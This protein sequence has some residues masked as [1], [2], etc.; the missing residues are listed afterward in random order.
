M[1]IRPSEGGAF[2]HVVSLARGLAEHG[3]EVALCGPH[4]A[5]GGLGVELLELDIQRPLSLRADVGSIRGLRR[6]L[7]DYGP[8]LIHAHG[9]KGG[10]MARVARRA[11]VGAPLVFTPHGYAFAGHFSRRSERQAYRAIERA[12]SPLASRVICVCQAEAR[13]AASV[14]S[15]KRI[16]VVY[17]GID[18]PPGVASDP[19]IAALPGPVISAVTGLRP[20]KGDE[21]LVEAFAS[22]VESGRAGTLVIA[23][24][25]PEREPITRMIEAAGIAARVKL[26]GNV[27]DV[28]TLLAASDLF[29]LPSWAESFPYSVIEAMSVGLPII[30]TDVGGIGEAIEDGITGRLVAPRDARGLSAALADLHD[31]RNLATRLGE[32]ARERAQARFSLSRMVADTLAVYRELGVRA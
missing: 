12:L 24:D 11:G 6:I 23:G 19:T 4:G 10:V 18:A 25:G 3:H 8:D 30:A 17:N 1:V 20:G 2:G 31:E 28:F 5:H 13:L 14:G 26:P 7:R 16:R 22:F 15:R 9:S 32:A 29:V 21:T 27:P